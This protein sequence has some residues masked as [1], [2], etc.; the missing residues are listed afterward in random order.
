MSRWSA[1]RA[2]LNGQIYVPHTVV[3]TNGMGSGGDGPGFA[4]ELGD[5]VTDSGA[6]DTNI[7][8]AYPAAAFPMGPSVRTGIANTLEVLRDVPRGKLALMGYSEGA[9]VMNHVWR[10]HIVNPSGQLHYLLPDVVAIVLFGDPMRAPGICNGNLRA[11]FPVPRPVD[12]FT[13]GGIAGPDN[14]RP[15]QTPAFLMSCNNDGDLYGAA[16][17]GESPWTQQTGVG[18]DETL[19]YNLVQDFDGRNVLAFVQEAMAILGVSFGSVAPAQTPGN[20]SAISLGN[21]TSIAGLDLA[22]AV[23]LIEGLIAGMPTGL[24]G[25]ASVPA[26]GATTP[27]H[28]IALIEA[29]WNGGMFVLRGLGPH[30]DYEKFIPA[31]A[32]YVNQRAAATQ[33]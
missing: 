33:P 22:T 6:W 13:T 28:V 4:C 7:K 16:P 3:S 1:I 18:H 17:V 5:V 20:A 14:L 11:G 12:G 32:D 2:A 24:G 26:T 31:M 27:A 30:G 25:I 8:V 19:I 10:D 29:L 9:L 15:E 23:S 21:T